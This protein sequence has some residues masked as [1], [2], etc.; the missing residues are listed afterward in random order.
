[1]TH[2]E[3]SKIVRCAYPEAVVRKRWMP[4]RGRTWF[5]VVTQSGSSFV[6][7]DAF[8]TIAKAVVDAA[9]KLEMERTAKTHPSW[10]EPLL[11]R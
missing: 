11:Y 4:K 5:E 6:L 2:I 9:L 8:P 7:S 3:A 10:G 1:M